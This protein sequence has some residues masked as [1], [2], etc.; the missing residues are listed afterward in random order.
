MEMDSAFS[1]M[2]VYQTVKDVSME[3]DFCTWMDFELDFDSFG[4]DF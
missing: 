4:M 2:D 1:E 3:F